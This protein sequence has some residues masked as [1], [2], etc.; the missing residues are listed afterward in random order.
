MKCWFTGCLLLLAAHG[1]LAQDPSSACLAGLAR[2]PALQPLASRT[3]LA[4]LKTMTMDMLTDTSKPAPAE[5]PLIAQW[6]AGL[7][8]CYEA[9]RAFRERVV[10]PESIAVLD[11][12]EDAQEAL[13]ARFSSGALAYGE[14]NSDRVA[15]RDQFLRT[16]SQTA[17][18]VF[19]ARAAQAQSAQ[20]AL[21]D[22]ERQQA[23][24]SDQSE[25]GASPL[26]QNLMNGAAYPLPASGMPGLPGM[27]RVPGVPGG[28]ALP[29]APA[30]PSGIAAAA[31]ARAGLGR[32]CTGK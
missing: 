24:G 1:A 30:D 32:D 7:K 18:Q 9:G 10:A 16:A 17:K 3:P 29:G 15:L 2:E 12:Q 25:S 31:C 11:A 4:S 26:Q 23:L 14:F 19:D 5:L 20:Q 27:P 6:S 28:T 8:Q 21:L 22:T 13:V